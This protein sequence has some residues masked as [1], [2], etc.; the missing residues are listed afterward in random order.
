M[1]DNN[2]KAMKVCL[3][4][5]ATEAKG[6]AIFEKVPMFIKKYFTYILI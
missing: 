6:T 4:Q 1:N 2:R 5:D 3:I